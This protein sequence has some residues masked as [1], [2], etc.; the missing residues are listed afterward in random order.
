VIEDVSYAQLLRPGA[1]AL[2]E[3]ELGGAKAYALKLQDAHVLVRNNDVLP[4]VD[5]KTSTR[6]FGETAA[7]RYKLSEPIREIGALSSMLFIP[8]S[9]NYYHFLM[10]NLPGTIFLRSAPG[11]RATLGLVNEIPPAAAALVHKLLPQLAGNRPVDVV[12]VAPGDYAARDVILR[13]V[14]MMPFSVAFCRTV[15]SIVL[16]SRGLDDSL[17]GPGAKLFV[18]RDGG[19]GGR[20]LLNQDEVEAWC[21][22]YGYS[23]IDPG[24]LSLEEQI[25]LFSQATHIV[26]VEGAALANLVFATKAQRVLILASPVTW[27]EQ[28]F[29]DLSVRAGFPLTTV[30]G[31]VAP[32]KATDRR[33]DFVMPIEK[34]VRLEF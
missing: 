9:T 21:A 29:W 34:F 25:I 8:G 31:E 16:R 7:H 14:P 3:A 23:S 5:G 19:R 24:M 12:T 2:M 33:A 11:P 22:R 15:Q 4:V 20:A 6:E 28:F 26:G 10:Y 27:F 30:Y 1:A 13:A 17:H 32:E 18:R